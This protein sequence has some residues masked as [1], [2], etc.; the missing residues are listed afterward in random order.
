M[1]RKKKGR[2]DWAK[3]YPGSFIG[4]I[5]IFLTSYSTY[6]SAAQNPMSHAKNGK[7]YCKENYIEKEFWLLETTWMS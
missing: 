1:C 2:S 3:S 4:Q 5:E 7:S 6:I